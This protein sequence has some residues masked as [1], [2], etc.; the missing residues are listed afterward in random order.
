MLIDWFTVVAQII[1]FGVLLLILRAFLF[2]PILAA[3]EEREKNIAESFQQAEKLQSEAS[4]ARQHHEEKS[5]ALDLTRESM[6]AKIQEEAEVERETL[7]RQA[8]EEVDQKKED[9]NQN[10][11]EEID[12]FLRSLTVSAASELCEI[13]ER[14][15]EEMTDSTLTERAVEMFLKHLRNHYSNGA[16]EVGNPSVRQDQPP[17]LTCSQELTI[18]L[19]KR[20]ET[21]L[22][23]LGVQGEIAFEIN[24]EL[25][26]GCQLRAGGLV[27]EW[28]LGAYLDTLKERM[29]IELRGQQ[30]VS[31]AESA[32]TS[33]T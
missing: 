9:W 19:Q 29:L 16:I 30:A 12:T 33:V 23:E 32:Q 27:I 2:K 25:L 15:L 26:C 31:S 22:R 10:V 7:L 6:I 4:Q 21:E 3:I 8:R 24:P 11:Q 13:T 28:D 1:N 14:A 20:I 17:I 18:A 5:R